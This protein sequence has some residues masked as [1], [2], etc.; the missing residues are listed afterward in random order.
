[1]GTLGDVVTRIAY[2]ELFYRGE[3]AC[4]DGIQAHVN[5]GWQVAHIQGRPGGHYVV[6]F[7][8]SEAA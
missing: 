4:L 2:Q 6:V 7:R 1:M 8:M 5:A 3:R